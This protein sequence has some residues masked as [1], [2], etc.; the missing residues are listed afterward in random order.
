MSTDGWWVF[1]SG[2]GLEESFFVYLDEDHQ[3]YQAW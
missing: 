2:L 1:L 3:K